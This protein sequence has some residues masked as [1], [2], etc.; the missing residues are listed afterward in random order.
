MVEHM[1]GTPL[2]VLAC[3]DCRGALTD[4]G[5]GTLCTMCRTAFPTIDGIFVLL[6]SSARNAELELEPLRTA[7]AKLGGADAEA[8]TATLVRI[9]AGSGE[10]SWDWEDEEFWAREYSDLTAAPEEMNWND[11]LWDREFLRRHALAKLGGLGGKVVLD[12]GCGEGQT[13]RRVLVG[14]ADET[15]TYIGADISLNA[16]KLNRMRNPCSGGIYI[17]CSANALPLREGIADLIT[18]FGIL[19]HTE[20]KSATLSEDARLL[21]PGGVM[22]LHEV[23]ARPTV[24]ALLNLPGEESSAHDEEVE[25]EEL[26]ATI[27]ASDQIEIVARREMHSPLYSAAIRVAPGI[28]LHRYW[29]WTLTRVLDAA[30]LKVFGRWI[31]LFR[32]AAVLMVLQKR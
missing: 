4:V 30:V 20:R 7:A 27:Q 18:Y 13:F 15:T 10:R 8:F 25:R 3:P 2:A 23:L 17:L 21:K 22:M 14:A 16:L 9:V 24:S 28:V 5:P 31:P 29:A 19:H 32:P 1:G 26:Y 6:P 11:R 12:V